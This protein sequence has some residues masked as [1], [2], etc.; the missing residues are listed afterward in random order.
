MFGLKEEIRAR[1]RRNNFMQWERP[2]LENGQVAGGDRDQ[3]AVSLCVCV[4]FFFN[5]ENQSFG[6]WSQNFGHLVDDL[7]FC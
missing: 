7:V 6:F 5:Y 4:C 1:R 2:L 3:V